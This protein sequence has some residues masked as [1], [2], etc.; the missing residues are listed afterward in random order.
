LLGGDRFGGQ[1]AVDLVDQFTEPVQARLVSIFFA[2]VGMNDDI[3]LAGKIVEYH[4]FFRSQQHD[5]GR[6]DGVGLGASAQLRLDIA[7]GVIAKIT[8]ES[9]GEAR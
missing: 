4:Q 1:R 7:H 6:A 8:D 3:E 5:I 9:A 2:R